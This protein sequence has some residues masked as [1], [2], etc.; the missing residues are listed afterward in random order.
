[1]SD[2]SP[3]SLKSI[4]MFEANL[5]DD[6]NK[7]SQVSLWAV[8]EEGEIMIRMNVSKQNPQGDRWEYVD[9]REKLTS[10]SV[11]GQLIKDKD[12]DYFIQVD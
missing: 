6:E 11:S 3:V 2:E 4:S 12:N 5:N 9:C 7:K 10:V 8:N 1:M